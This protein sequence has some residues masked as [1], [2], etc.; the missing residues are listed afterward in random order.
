[1]SIQITKIFMDYS[2]QKLAKG[3]VYPLR[4]FFEPDNGLIYLSR[5]TDSISKSLRGSFDLDNRPFAYRPTSSISKV[6][7]DFQEIFGKIDVENLGDQKIHGLAHKN[8]QNEGL[9]YF[10]IFL[11]WKWD[12]FP[13]G[14]NWLQS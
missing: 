7:M 1:M 10:G 5:K 12:G 11:T 3:G 4:G 8:M 2:T 6:L 13:I 9:T 14:T